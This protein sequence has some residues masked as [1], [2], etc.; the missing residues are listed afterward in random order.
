MSQL[1]PCPDRQRVKNYYTASTED[2][3]R[4]YESDWHHHM[5]YG[6]ER[7][8]PP[9]GNPT[10]N[11][12]RYMAERVDLKPG[13]RVLDSGCGVGGSSIWLAQQR[14]CSCVSLNIMESQLRLVARYAQR[15]AVRHLVEPV[16][17]NFLQTPFFDN[18]F[19]VVWA[20]ESFDH[21]P[22]KGAWVKEKFRLLRPG[23]RLIVADGFRAEQEFLGKNKD[24]YECF[25][26]GW[27]V[28]HLARPSEFWQ[29][30]ATAGFQQVV[31]EDIT[32]DVMPHAQA[33]FRFGLLFVPLRWMG[34]KLGITS[35]EK[36]GNALATWHQYTT[37]KRGL[38]TYRIVTAVKPCT[39]Y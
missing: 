39:N 12:V 20:V 35:A 26:R 29:D 27:A 1:S 28:P 23:G 13:E 9:G 17:A 31:D 21:A 22:D 37:L 33:I 3:L 5:H 16:N 18:S 24:A 38:W 2:Y 8:L 19:D 36:M 4:W 34:Q 30:L 14:D 10:E 15:H 7:D 11:L 32:S 6:F 25:L